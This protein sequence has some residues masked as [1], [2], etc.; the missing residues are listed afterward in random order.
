MKKSISILGCGWLGLPLG[1]FLVE[2]G[3]V[4]KGS[5]TRLEK[6]REIEQRGV[7]PFLIEVSETVRGEKKSEFFNSDLLILNI[8]PGR[9]R[10]NVE[11]FHPLQIQAVVEE[12]LKEGIP[13]LV[14]ISST[15]VYSDVNRLVTEE[16]APLPDTPSGRALLQVENHLRN[17]KEIKATILRMAGLVGGERKAGRFLAGRKNAANGRAPVNLVHRDDCI[18]VIYEIIRLEKWGALFNVCADLHPLREAFYRAQA[19]K[20]GL[21]PPTFLPDETPSFKIVSNERVKREL[22]Y[23]FLYP[24]PMGFP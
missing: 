4:V 11:V 19:E 18:R 9:R 22:G 5:T 20:I 17:Q 1:A 13:R 12:A 10:D 21:E 2:K 14:F 8:P 6:F 3:Y 24:D 23:E 7:A 16:D 15:G